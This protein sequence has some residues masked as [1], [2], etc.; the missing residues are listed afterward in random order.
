M[1][2][3][4]LCITIPEELLCYRKT[5]ESS[6]SKIF[7]SYEASVE[8]I[9]NENGQIECSKFFDE[10]GKIVKALCYSGSFV[11]KKIL[12]NNEKVI[13]AEEYCENG[14]SKKVF[15]NA[16]GQI[17]SEFEYNY[18]KQGRI[19][20]I[21]KITSNSKIC[22]K[23]GYDELQRV[24]SREITVNDEKVDFQKYRF[25][26]LDRVVGYQDK[27]QKIKIIQLSA[28][29]ELIYYTITDKIGNEI[30]VINYFD[31]SGKY[32]KTEI[33]LNG[34]KIIIQDI[35]Y[36]DNIMLKN[37]CTTEEDLDI[38]ISNLFRKDCTQTKRTNCNDISDERISINVHSTT[39]PIS[40]RK[41]LLYNLA[42]GA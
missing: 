41:R 40:I 39:L 7:N 36:V 42:I 3:E 24:N 6:P 32:L 33:S 19:I 1:T 38:I 17:Q 2:K 13:Q 21:N 23:Y 35:G 28:S 25:D 12:Y 20:A 30:S 4:S 9:T 18:N 14:I 26:I 22:I 16:S 8:N 34:H 27:N 37:P 31:F 11:S 29:N 15:Y 10:Q 5:S